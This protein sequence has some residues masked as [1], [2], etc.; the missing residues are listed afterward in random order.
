[1]TTP[2]LISI[3]AGICVFVK[4]VES[5]FAPGSH[6]LKI[7][8]AMIILAHLEHDLTALGSNPTTVSLK[9]YE[10]LFHRDMKKIKAEMM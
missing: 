7:K 5:H 8:E 10:D 2:N 3:V 1:M 4:A 6:A 9:A